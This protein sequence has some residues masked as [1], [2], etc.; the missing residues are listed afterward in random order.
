[1][2]CQDHPA[3]RWQWGSAMIGK[4]YFYKLSRAGADPLHA[5]AVPTDGLT[6]EP[7]PRPRGAR[8]SCGW[9]SMARANLVGLPGGVNRDR[10][11]ER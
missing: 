8:G 11:T 2:F 1:M 9:L 6:R 3:N 10:P 4:I 7:D 5:L